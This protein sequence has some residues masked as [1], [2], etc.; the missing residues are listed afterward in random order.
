MLVEAMKKSGT[1]DDVAK[2][3]QALLSS[4]Y[5]GVWNIRYDSTGEAVFDFDILH[6]KKG[7]AIASTHIEPK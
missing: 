3:K 7:G 1:V 4:R 2:V 6:M 5:K